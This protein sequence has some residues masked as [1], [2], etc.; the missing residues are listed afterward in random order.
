MDESRCTPLLAVVADLAEEGRVPATV[1]DKLR[2]VG[3]AGR[4]SACVTVGVALAASIGARVGPFT[5]AALFDVAAILGLAFGVSRNG[6]ACAVAMPL[7]DD[8]MGVSG[9]FRHL[10]LRKR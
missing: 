9:T 7:S 10:R 2:D 5:G 3:F 1:R 6:G 4:V 8:A